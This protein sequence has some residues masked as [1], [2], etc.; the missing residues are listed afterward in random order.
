MNRSQLLVPLAL[1]V[2]LPLAGCSEAVPPPSRGAWLVD[3]KAGTHGAQ[4][5]I[6]G[7]QPVYV[8]DMSNPECN[9]RTAPVDQ[10]QHCGLAMDGYNGVRS[11][12]AV[13]QQGATYHLEGVAQQGAN[14]LQFQ[15]DGITAAANDTAPAKG[16][17]TFTSSQ[18]VETYTSPETELCDFFFN[19][20]QSAQ[21]APGHVWGTFRCATLLS[22][23]SVPSQCAI[24]PSFFAFE[25]CDQ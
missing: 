10:G 2:L 13:Q 19:D 18:V 9:G 22:A 6:A 17:V 14:F 5:T 21:L 1:G 4:C 7:T 20:N 11:Y 16:R 15:V 12:C 3:F 8:G 24:Q 23:T 25:N